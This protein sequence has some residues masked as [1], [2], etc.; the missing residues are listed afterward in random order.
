LEAFHYRLVAE[1][2]EAA[3]ELKVT[4]NHMLM[5]EVAEALVQTTAGQVELAVLAL[6]V[7]VDLVMARLKEAVAQAVVVVVVHIRM[8]VLLEQEV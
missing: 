6:V 7:V 8:A 4:L 1:V 2:V 5:V 3:L